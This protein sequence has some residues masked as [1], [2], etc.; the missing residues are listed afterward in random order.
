MLPFPVFDSCCWQTLGIS[1]NEGSDLADRKAREK[2]LHS[3]FIAVNDVIKRV[4][5]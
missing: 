1:P 4:F 3:R 5:R 2:L